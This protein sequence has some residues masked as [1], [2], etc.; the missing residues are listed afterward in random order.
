MD[1]FILHFEQNAF[2][3]VGEEDN[4][5]KIDSLKT[6]VYG[7]LLTIFESVKFM[8]TMN[9]LLRGGIFHSSVLVFIR[10]EINISSRVEVTVHSF[11]QAQ[12]LQLQNL[13]ASPPLEGGRKKNCNHIM[14]KD[15]G[16]EG[17]PHCA[18]G[19][20]AT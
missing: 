20:D 12:N 7:S 13:F 17:C 18:S 16:E 8:Q 10:L 14:S 3:S 11:P 2:K 15:V 19:P 6:C 9:M 5:S 4:D 1:N